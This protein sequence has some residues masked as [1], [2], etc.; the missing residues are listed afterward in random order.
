M[1]SRVEGGGADSGSSSSMGSK[2][3]GR[4][5]DSTGEHKISKVGEGGQEEEEG[6]EDLSSH[7][8]LSRVISKCTSRR[9]LRNTAG[10]EF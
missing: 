10:S 9:C 1:W 6:G 5:E 7:L 2:V 3:R 4:P 8:F